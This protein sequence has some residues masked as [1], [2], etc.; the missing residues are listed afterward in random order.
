MGKFSF[1]IIWHD[2]KTTHSETRPFLLALGIFLMCY[3]GLTISFYPWMIPFHYTIYQAAA[4]GPGL[5]FM[6]VGVAPLLPLIL[7][8]T[9]YCYYII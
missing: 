3:L 9:G 4:A 2:L 1:F 8:Y 7:A 6:L 5:S